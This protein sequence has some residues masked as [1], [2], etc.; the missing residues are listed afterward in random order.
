MLEFYT[1]CFDCEDVIAITEEMIAAAAQA[2][3]PD[4]AALSYKGRPLALSTPF[5]RLS[6]KD[7]VANA[8]RE[9]GLSLE[10]ATLDDAAAL[11][12]WAGGSALAGRRN[13]KGAALTPERY[14]GLSHGKRV[15][16]LF[17]D[18]AEGA[19]WDPTFIVDFP[20]ARSRPWPRPTPTT[21]ARPSASSCTW[22][23]WRSPT[24]S[25]S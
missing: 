9:E 10:R 7:A 14:A 21:P 13:H 1:A 4:P 11:E 19:I 15:A 2:V 18:L 23:A 5:A 6:M 3:V 12:R 8:A 16:Q 25:P 17:E 20:V 22:P 24:A